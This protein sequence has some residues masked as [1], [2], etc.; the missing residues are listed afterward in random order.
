MYN[1]TA[2]MTRAMQ[3]I[4]ETVLPLAYTSNASCYIDELCFLRK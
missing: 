2:Y 3:F 4:S 1:V